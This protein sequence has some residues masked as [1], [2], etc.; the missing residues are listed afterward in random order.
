[1]LERCT[2]GEVTAVP[3]VGSSHHVLGVEHLLSELRNGD[4][5]VLLASAGSQRGITSHKEVKSGEGNHVDG[6]LPQIGVEL[7][8]ETQAGGDTRHDDGDEVVKVTV[9]WGRQLKS[10]ETDVV[11]SLIV[12]AESLVRVLDKLVD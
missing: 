11:Q 10:A 2:Y 7:T 4:G 6:Q 5:T 9:R 1:M 8:G 3:G 12:N